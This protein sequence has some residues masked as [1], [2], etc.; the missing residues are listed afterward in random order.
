MPAC[1][2]KPVQ[3]LNIKLELSGLFRRNFAGRH[4]Y[5]GLASK[6]EEAGEEGHSCVAEGKNLNTKKRDNNTDREE[7]D[8]Q[9]SLFPHPSLPS[10]V[11]SREGE[12]TDLPSWKCNVFSFFCLFSVGMAAV[13]E[14]SL[15]QVPVGLTPVFEADKHC[16]VW[17]VHFHTPTQAQQHVHTHILV[18]RYGEGGLAR[19]C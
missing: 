9:I 2:R 12:D 16:G 15:C 4:T 13:K 10:S 18:V 3:W 5:L 6:Q 11:H 8:W 19:K 17:E 14:V 7:L 1:A